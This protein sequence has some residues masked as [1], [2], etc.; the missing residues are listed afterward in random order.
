MGACVSRP[1]N[2]VGG[3]LGGLKKKS[4]RGRKGV[5]RKVSFQV[6]D[7]S[8][9]KVEKPAHLDR[10]FINP[11]YKGSVFLSGNL[12]YVFIPGSFVSCKFK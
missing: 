12:C 1:D 10:S 5:K 6:P 7:R 3:R 8:L 11:T 4:R 9:D 2:C